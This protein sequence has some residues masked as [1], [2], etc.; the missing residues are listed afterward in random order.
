MIIPLNKRTKPGEVSR[1][2][3]KMLSSLIN[4]KL[5]AFKVL[6]ANEVFQWQV[7]KDASSGF[8]GVKKPF[9]S[10]YFRANWDVSLGTRDSSPLLDASLRP[11]RSEMVAPY[12]EMVRK[13]APYFQPERALVVLGHKTVSEVMGSPVLIYNNSWYGKWL[14]N[15]GENAETFLRRWPNGTAYARR[16]DGGRSGS[17]GSRFMEK[18]YNFF[19][20]RYDYTRIIG[21]ARRNYERYVKKG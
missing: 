15:G 3:M 8:G 9:F 12:D 13:F 2:G 11:G 6:V 1:D 4:R 21:E 10:G 5:A 20:E 17:D 16:K 14:N 19:R 18:C 7:P